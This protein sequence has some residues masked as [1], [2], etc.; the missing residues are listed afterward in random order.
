MV[1]N[2]Q[3]VFT[4]G[5]PVVSMVEK[6]ISLLREGS[7]L[8]PPINVTPSAKKNGYDHDADAERAE[9]PGCA[10]RPFTRMGYCAC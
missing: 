3:L 6:M 5:S 1:L 4:Q 9:K 8:T 2:D 10:C 7:G